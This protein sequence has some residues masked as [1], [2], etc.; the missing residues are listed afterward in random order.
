M[1]QRKGWSRKAE[2]NITVIK[3]RTRDCRKS[4][5]KHK[6]APEIMMCANV[7]TTESVCKSLNFLR[8]PSFEAMFI[9]GIKICRAGS[10]VKNIINKAI[11]A[12][13]TDVKMAAAAKNEL[14]KT[15][16]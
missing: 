16:T 6:T 9:A 11:D 1:A 7:I 5:K 8:S 10:V 12:T 3:P 4:Y 2:A 13:G 14:A 15:K